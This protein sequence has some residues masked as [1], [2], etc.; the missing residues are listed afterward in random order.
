MKK[1]TLLKVKAGCTLLVLVLAFFV[2]N[3]QPARAIP[4]EVILSIPEAQRT[5]IQKIQVYAD[6]VWKTYGAKLVGTT[7]RNTL[8]RLAMDAAKRVA[9][10][11]EG[12]KPTFIISELGGYWK[13][14]GDAAAGDF[15]DGLGESWGVDL[16]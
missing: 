13:N 6:K 10:S 14:V 3:V 4:T 1:D 8:N 7:L 15:I 2:T 16:C 12:Q 9:T 5:I 11:G